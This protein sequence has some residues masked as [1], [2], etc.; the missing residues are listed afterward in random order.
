MK[1]DEV[2]QDGAFLDGHKRGAYAVDDAGRYTL[3]ATAGWDAETE[4]TRIALQVADAQISTAWQRVREGRSSPL[5][6]HL[7]ARQLTTSLVAAYARTFRFV[8]WWHQR[9][10]PFAALSDA[11]LERYSKALRVPVEK[12]KVLP[13]QPESWQ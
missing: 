11:W 4:A 5:H 1:A 6:Y 12:L 7:A 3:V 8:V 10:G 9:P 13:E 2:P